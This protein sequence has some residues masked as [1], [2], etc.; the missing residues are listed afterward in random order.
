MT[1]Y[2]RKS[3]SHENAIK[4]IPIL[5]Y[6]SFFDFPRG[7][8]IAV[9]D[10]VI[11]MDDPFDDGIDDYRDYYDV[12]FLRNAK[13]ED[14]VTVPVDLRKYESIYLGQI[15]TRDV[16]FDPTNRKWIRCAKLEQMVKG[17]Q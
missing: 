5:N 15:P 12:C 17:L 1:S 14:F 3:I 6:G 11:E 10:I 13:V 16:S 4:I 9:N 7:L 8:Y 2:T